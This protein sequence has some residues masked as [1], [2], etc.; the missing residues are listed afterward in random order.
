MLDHLSFGYLNC[1]RWHFDERDE[2]VVVLSL[3]QEFALELDIA[4]LARFYQHIKHS[5][6]DHRVELKRNR[7][8]SPV[9]FKGGFA[10]QLS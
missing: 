7:S 8:S 3:K 10:N 1:L 9:R 4:I 2:L 5:V 6:R